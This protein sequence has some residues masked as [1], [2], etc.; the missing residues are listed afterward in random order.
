[1][2]LD[3]TTLDALKAEWDAL[4]PLSPENEAR[5]WKKLRLE[6]NYHSNHIEGNTL[7]YGETE[8]LLIHGQTTG[9]HQLRDYEEMKA[10]DLG[11]AHVRDLAAEER[12]LGETDIRGL[13]KI[14][15]KEPFWKEAITP[16]G[17]PTRKQIIPGDYKVSP[18]NVRTATGEIFAFAS[19]EETPAKMHDLVTWLRTSV[20]TKSLHHIELVAK[21]HH[22]F[23]LIHPFDDGNG[24]VARLLVNYVLLRLGYPPL[25]VKSEDKAGYLAALRKADVGDLQALVSY[26]AVQMEWSLSL[27]VR[28]A[29]GE[30]IEE[31]SDVE[32]ELAIFVRDQG[33]HKDRVKRRSPEIIKELSDVSWSGIFEKLENKLR[34]LNPLF[35]ETDIKAVPHPQGVEKGWRPSFD[36]FV[37][38]GLGTSFQVIFGFRGYKGR[39]NTPFDLSAEVALVL[40][41]FEYQIIA[42]GGSWARRLYSEPILSDEAEA[43][44]VQLL[45][46]LFDKVKKLSE[47][48]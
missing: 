34:K 14:I 45:K 6:W 15:L 30:S 21:L 44:S 3:F 24:R 19:P 39:A 22:E 13:N 29:K 41:D 36:H 37:A 5:L 35:L 27:G 8:L 11:I 20:E 38:K 25:I 48:K 4:Q 46:S 16:G 42:L 28:A 17:Q 10:H 7:T 40:S 2:N 9:T 33:A 31:L 1:M 18:N 12:P 32:K 23:V 43:L 47:T 26:L